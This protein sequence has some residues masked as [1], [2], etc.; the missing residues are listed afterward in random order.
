MFQSNCPDEL[1]QFALPNDENELFDEEDYV[2]VAT[3][4]D[5][6]IANEEGEEEVTP[7]KGLD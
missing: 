5:L 6:S 1:P 7:I 4:H 2:V 3:I